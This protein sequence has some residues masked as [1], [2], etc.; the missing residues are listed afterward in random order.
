V[1][2]GAQ[3]GKTR[4][5]NGLGQLG[6]WRRKP[7]VGRTYESIKVWANRALRGDGGEKST[8]DARAA[9]K[10]AARKNER[11]HQARGLGTI[12]V[13]TEG[14]KKA[15]SEMESKT[16]QGLGGRE[17]EKEIVNHPKRSGGAGAKAGCG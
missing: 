10:R 8:A 16:R 9:V 14:N 13:Q 15:A 7:I 12:S 5:S 6:L 11:G 1:G 2:R 3:T 4:N 17:P